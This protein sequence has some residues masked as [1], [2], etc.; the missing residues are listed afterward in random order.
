MKNYINH[1]ERHLNATAFP[2]LVEMENTKLLCIDDDD[3]DR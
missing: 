3:D 1:F 2:L